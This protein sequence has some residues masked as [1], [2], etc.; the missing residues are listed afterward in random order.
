MKNMETDELWGKSKKINNEIDV[1]ISYYPKMVDSLDKEMILNTAKQIPLNILKARS[2][3]TGNEY[4]EYMEKA[5]IASKA[6]SG[7]LKYA[8][9]KEA[10]GNVF[11]ELIMEQLME[12]K[13]LFIPEQEKKQIEAA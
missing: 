8:L 12:I 1:F 9:S 13:N 2:R 11:Y 4:E 6:L 5:S 10:V 7:M 3:N